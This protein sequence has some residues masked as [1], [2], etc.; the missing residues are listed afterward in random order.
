MAQEIEVRTLT[1]QAVA[2]VTIPGIQTAAVDAAVGGALPDI[3]SH[4]EANGIEMVGHPFARFHGGDGDALDLEVGIPVG[5]PFP[6]TEVIRAGQLPGGE[7]I[8]TVHVGP[9]DG[10]REALA[11]LADWRVANARTAGG[12]YWEVYLDDPTQVAPEAQRTELVEPLAPEG[13]AA[14]TAADVANPG[15]GG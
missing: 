14:G 11:A 1:P 13:E 3:Y 10:L 9:R 7:A 8:A 4:L 12:P 2:S 15:G 5:G 6:T